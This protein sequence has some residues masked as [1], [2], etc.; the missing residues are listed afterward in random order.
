MEGGWGAGV[1][2][3]GS[4]GVA[5]LGFR[6]RRGEDYVVEKASIPPCQKAWRRGGVRRAADRGG[7]VVAGPA[8]R[9]G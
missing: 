3:R 6:G 5:A 9:G 8:E 7:C 1:Q 4:E 2:F